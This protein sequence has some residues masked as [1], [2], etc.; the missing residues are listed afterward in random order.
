MISG[1]STW[2]VQLYLIVKST[3]YSVYQNSGPD[4]T[5]S[6]FKNFIYDIYDIVT[7][8]VYEVT[9]IGDDEE[10]GKEDPNFSASFPDKVPNVTASN[11]NDDIEEL[12]E[13]KI[14]NVQ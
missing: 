1:P 14:Q 10:L 12:K 13:V 3:E 7:N 9:H 5:Y 11:N 2:W 8:F 6:I 4:S